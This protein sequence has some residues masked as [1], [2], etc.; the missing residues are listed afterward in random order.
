M[1]FDTCS[2]ETPKFY[3]QAGKRHKFGGITTTVHREDCDLFLLYKKSP[4]AIA[5]YHLPIQVTTQLMQW[6]QLWA[7]GKVFS[8]HKEQQLWGRSTE[9]KE[10]LWA[11]SPS[12]QP[13]TFPGGQAGRLGFFNSQHQS[14]KLCSLA[15]YSTNDESNCEMKGEQS[16]GSCWHWCSNY[17]WNIL[18]GCER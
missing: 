2:T 12:K 16:L 8:L 9:N 13:S 15:S 4:A 6:C 17:S 1:C 3:H 11:E 7:K 5:F 10:N 14:S 18:K